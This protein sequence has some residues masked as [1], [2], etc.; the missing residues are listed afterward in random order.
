M[1]YD[2]T[3]PDSSFGSKILLSIQL[4]AA[5][6]SIALIFS[7]FLFKKGLILH[8]ITDIDV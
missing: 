6:E 3:A 7:L 1:N 2:S 5:E 4:E 8:I